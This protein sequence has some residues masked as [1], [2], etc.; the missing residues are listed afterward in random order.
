[1]QAIPGF[2]GFYHPAFGC[3]ASHRVAADFAERG[4]PQGTELLRSPNLEYG[5]C[6]SAKAP[7]PFGRLLLDPRPY[8]L[9]T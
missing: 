8:K 7:P 9:R 4:C 6:A 5:T 2:G 1:M 3:F